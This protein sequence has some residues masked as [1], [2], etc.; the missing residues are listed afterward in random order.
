MS[1]R[2]AESVAL[3][4]SDDN[5]N[6]EHPMR[7]CP[8]SDTDA[9]SAAADVVVEQ[10]NAEANQILEDMTLRKRRPW[11]PDGS[12]VSGDIDLLGD[13]DVLDDEEEEDGVGCPLPS[14]PED[15]QLLEA[16]VSDLLHDLAIGERAPNRVTICG[17]A[18][19]FEFARVSAQQTDISNISIH[20]HPTETDAS[21]TTHR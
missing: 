20:R 13:D 2:P 7:S 10:L 4:T 15:N 18:I 3:S 16:E 9:T 11:N 5:I 1:R 14:T 8:T 19:I 12:L 17:R 21:L 6:A